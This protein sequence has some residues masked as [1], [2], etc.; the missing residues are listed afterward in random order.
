MRRAGTVFFDGDCAFCTTAAVWGSRH[1]SRGLEFVA[2][3]RADLAAAGLTAEQ[4]ER[5]LQFVGADDRRG[6]GGRA[7]GLL[8]HASGG[9]WRLPA[10]VALVPPTSW[11]VEGVYRIVAA[12][13]HRLPGGTPACRL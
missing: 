4:C 7:I 1:L 12:N 6:S 3:Q 9:A 5:A 11:L 8:L 10:A 2:Y 13:R